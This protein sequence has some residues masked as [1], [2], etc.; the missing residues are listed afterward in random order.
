[1]HEDRALFRD[2]KPLISFSYQN[3]QLEDEAMA[4]K[5]HGMDKT[6]VQIVKR[7]LSLPPKAARGNEGRPHLFRTRSAT[8]KAAPLPPIAVALNKP[9]LI[10]DFR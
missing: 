10:G 4:S 7:R 6:T 8:L 9:P 1:M 5:Q 3:Y 2:C